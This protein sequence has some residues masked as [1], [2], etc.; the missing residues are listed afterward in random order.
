[1]IGGVADPRYFRDF[2]HHAFFDA[3]L[4]GD[5]DHTAAVA[6]APETEVN[7]LVGIN[8]IQ[9]DPAFVCRQLRVNFRFNQPQHTF[10]Q[11]SVSIRSLAFDVG[12]TDRQ[13]TTG[14]GGVDIDMGIIQESDAGGINIQNEVLAFDLPFIANQIG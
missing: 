9:G 13:L 3:L 6:S 10:G 12:C 4:Q 14:C 8:G 7:H 5:I 11:R 1:M 2:S